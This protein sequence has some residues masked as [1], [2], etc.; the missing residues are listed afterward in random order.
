MSKPTVRE[1]ELLNCVPN[2]W[3]DPLLTGSMAALRGEPGKWGCP[4]IERLLNAIRMK[5]ALTLGN[6][7]L[8]DRKRKAGRR[9]RRG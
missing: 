8:Q 4:D 6:H 7:E 1:Q 3:C 2:N 9:G 5:L